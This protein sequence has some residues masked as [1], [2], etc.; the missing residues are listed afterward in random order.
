MYEDTEPG[1]SFCESRP[2]TPPWRTAYLQHHSR[3]SHV[4]SQDVAASL[5]VRLGGARLLPLVTLRL[6]M[7]TQWTLLQQLQRRATGAR[8]SG[9]TDGLVQILRHVR[10]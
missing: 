5:A 10:Q 7:T 4:L 8:Q 2:S 3:S 9:C 6:K 1:R